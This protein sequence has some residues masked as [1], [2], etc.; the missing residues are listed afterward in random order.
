MQR[1]SQC[2]EGYGT[3]WGSGWSATNAST[4]EQSFGVRFSNVLLQP[5]ADPVL[6]V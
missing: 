4:E 6:N 5:G 3:G 1:T 2:S